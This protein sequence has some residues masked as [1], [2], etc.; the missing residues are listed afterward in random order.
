MAGLSRVPVVLKDVGERELL[1]ISIVEN[2]QREDLNP[3]EEAQAISMLMDKFNLN[4]EEAADILGRSRSAVANSLRL[5]ALPEQI[6]KMVSGGNLSAGH[7]RAL[8]AVKDR[9][10]MI[11]AADHVAANAL[12]VRETE[13]YAKKLAGSSRDKQKKPV[14]R[15]SEFVE[16]ESSLSEMLETKVQLVGNDKRGKIVIEYFNKEQLFSL[17]EL[18]QSIKR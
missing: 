6:S 11:Y 17:Y 5:L 3:I 18:F 14:K 1:Q 8:L 15:P 10:L 4:Q 16:A 7:A 2:I 13:D 9:K 12:S